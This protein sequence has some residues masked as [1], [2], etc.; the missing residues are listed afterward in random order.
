MAVRSH[1]LEGRF[2]WDQA[3]REAR[4]GGEPLTWLTRVYHGGVRL[5]EVAAALRAAD[6]ALFL[7]EG[8]RRFAV[9]RLRVDSARAEVVANGL[10]AA[11]IGRPFEPLGAD[12]AVRI[13]QVGTYAERKGVRFGALALDAALRRH[14]EVSVTFVGAGRDPEAVHADFG[15]DVRDRV[16]VI[17]R[18]PRGGDLPSLLRGHHVKLF[19][20]LA[21]GFSV[22]LIEAMACGLAPIASARVATPLVRDG[23]NGLLV[24]QRDPVAIEAAID[25]RLV[26]GPCAARPVTGGRARVGAEL[27]LG[28]DR[29]RDRGD[30][31]APL[32]PVDAGVVDLAASAR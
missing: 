12:E 26:Y 30:L 9:E 11:L 14:P 21:E 4:E 17:P 20:S 15:A 29:A 25:G 13:A 2:F 28:S 22:A 6:V 7:N 5:R 10:P 3:V 24:P 31:R 1:G 19:P 27:R 23:E 8:D 32:G 16:G 18:Y